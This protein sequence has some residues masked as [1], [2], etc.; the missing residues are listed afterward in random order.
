MGL[1]FGIILGV[2]VETTHHS[3]DAG[4]NN[5][6][7]IERVDIEHV[8]VFVDGVEYIEVFS[9]LKGMVVLLLCR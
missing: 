5:L 6:V 7:G 2:R 8:E 1:I 9:Y 4:A 3:I